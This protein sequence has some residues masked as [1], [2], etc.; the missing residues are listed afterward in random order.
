VADSL[1]NF[2]LKVPRATALQQNFSRKPDSKAQHDA[3]FC[4]V[5][6]AMLIGAM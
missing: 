3:D 6:R 4:S 5:N 2:S 1:S